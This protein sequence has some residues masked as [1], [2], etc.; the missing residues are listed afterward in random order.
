MI[1]FSDQTEKHKTPAAAY[2]SVADFSIILTDIAKGVLP[3]GSQM[4]YPLFTEEELRR[5]M[6]EQMTPPWENRPGI[7][8]YNGPLSPY[9]HSM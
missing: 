4:P 2:M 7:G 3:T 5:N 6:Q 8:E 9:F 1:L